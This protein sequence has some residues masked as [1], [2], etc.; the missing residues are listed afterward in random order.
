ML[1]NIR[2]CIRD[3]ISQNLHDFKLKTYQQQIIDTVLQRHPDL[4]RPKK[5]QNFAALQ[6]QAQDKELQQYLHIEHDLETAIRD[7]NSEIIDTQS[8]IDTL[9]NEFENPGD[10]SNDTILLEKQNADL[11]NLEKSLQNIKQKIKKMTDSRYTR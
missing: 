4:I 6:R 9:N 2:K 8:R 5:I 11:E 3:I 10:T 1:T 7:K